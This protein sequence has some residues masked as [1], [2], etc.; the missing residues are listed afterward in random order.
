MVRISKTT[1]Q[2]LDRLQAQTGLSQPLLVDRA[3][4]LLERDVMSQQ[5]KTDFEAIA[6][7]AVA[8]AQYHAIVGAFDGATRDGL[9]RL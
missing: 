8:L 2:K 9:K 3:I 4:D 5:L 6:N 1:K 7:D